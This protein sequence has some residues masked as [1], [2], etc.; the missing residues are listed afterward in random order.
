MLR[1]KI[2]LKIKYKDYTENKKAVHH[3]IKEGYSMCLELDETYSTNFDNLFLFSYVLVSKKYNYYDIIINSKED[4]KT[5]IITL[6]G[7]IWKH[8]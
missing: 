4:V 3:L 7:E 6:W 2:S 1:T 5:K 8:F